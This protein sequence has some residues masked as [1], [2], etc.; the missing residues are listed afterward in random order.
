MDWETLL[1]LTGIYLLLLAGFAHFW[2]TTRKIIKVA[3][4]STQIL[5]LLRS[6]IVGMEDRKDEAS[7]DLEIY[8]RVMKK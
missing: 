3:E 5:E 2:F 4:G 7:R 1:A 8:E 6:I